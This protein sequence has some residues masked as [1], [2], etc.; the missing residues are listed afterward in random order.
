[1]AETETGRGGCHCGVVR[2]TVTSTVMPA[3]APLPSYGFAR[4]AE[5]TAQ[6]M[7]STP[8]PTPK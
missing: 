2:Y 4:N 3:R 5:S 6:I 1:M 8:T 7:T